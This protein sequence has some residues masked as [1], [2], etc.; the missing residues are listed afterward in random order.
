M[1]GD[2]KRMPTILPRPEVTVTPASD[3]DPIAPSGSVDIV[4]SRGG[5]GKSYRADG[6]SAPEI[7]KDAIEKVLADPY[8]GEWIG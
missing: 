2:R 7:V 4:I 1:M 5:K 8:S 6:S 3:R